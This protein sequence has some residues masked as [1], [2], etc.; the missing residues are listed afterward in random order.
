MEMARRGDAPSESKHRRTAEDDE[1]TGP[2]LAALLSLNMLRAT[3]GG[4]N[5]TWSEYTA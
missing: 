3:E 2:E 5:Y 1:K 4:C